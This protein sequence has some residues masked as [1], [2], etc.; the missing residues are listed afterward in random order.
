MTKEGF[1]KK[2]SFAGML[3]VLAL[4]A[5][6]TLFNPPEAYGDCPKARGTGSDSC[7]VCVACPDG[8]PSGGTECSSCLAGGCSEAKSCCCQT[9]MASCDTP[10][11]F[12]LCVE[13]WSF[14]T[15]GNAWSYSF[16]CCYCPGDC[17]RDN[18]RLACM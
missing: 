3:L 2:Q 8:S 13:S 7:S 17:P 18:C 5:L 4:V 15:C 1:Y 16:G 12:K 9:F 6:V 11:T 14:N 10:G